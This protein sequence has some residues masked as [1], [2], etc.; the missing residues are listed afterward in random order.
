[1][2]YRAKETHLYFT[3]AKEVSMSKKPEQPKLPIGKSLVAKVQE[4]RFDSPGPP[5]GII[6]M[7][8]VVHQSGLLQRRIVIRDLG[9]KYV[10]HTQAGEANGKPF[11]HHGDYFIKAFAEKSHTPEEEAEA[12]RKAW[13]RFEERARRSLGI[14]PPATNKLKEVA[15]IAV[16]IIN[17]ILPSDKEA[18]EQFIA[19]DYQLESD[20]ETFENLT[21]QKI[22]IGDAD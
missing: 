18:C 6:A 8:P 11:F 5:D 16:S 22:K 4:S 15:G 12:L 13:A 20:I 19:D 1:M 17:A 3:H 9:S 21:G 2:R 14:E 7:S 10:V